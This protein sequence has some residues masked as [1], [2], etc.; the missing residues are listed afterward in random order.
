MKNIFGTD[1]V[2]SKVGNPPFTQESLVTLSHA[3]AKWL[4]EKYTK[5]CIILAQDTRISG[6]WIKHTIT[7]T[8]L[9]YGIDILDT[10]VLPTPALFHLMKKNKSINCGLVISA[11]HN[12]YTDNGIKLIDYEFGKI[13]EID[14]LRISHYYQEKPTPSYTTFGTIKILSNAE[15]TYVQAILA[16]TNFKPHKPI[17]V[18]LDTAHGATYK[19]A[20]EIFKA[21][22]ITTITIN[23]N[24]N[25]ININNNC[26][27]LHLSSLQEAVIQHKADIGFAFDGDGDRIIAVNRYGHIKDGDDIL[28]ILAQHSDYKKEKILVGTSMSNQGFATFCSSQNK[29][30]IRAQIGDKYVSQELV[31]HNALLGGEQSGHIILRNLLATGD[32]ILVAIKILESIAQTNNWDLE[33]FTK[34]PQVLVNIQVTQKKDLSGEPFKTLIEEAEKKLKNGRILARYSGTEMLL[35][36]MAEAETKELAQSVSTDLANSFKSYL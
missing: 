11:S 32:G 34:Y 24:P 7:S 35:R 1:G 36:I 30:L 26:G 17:T 15:D 5:P 25:G 9:L 14:E 12:P 20:P 4:Q 19:V 21:L 31:A 27:A 16:L 29:Q 6:D 23:N 8:L 13:S 3:I 2:R 22:G 33:T 18:I 28:A 10:G